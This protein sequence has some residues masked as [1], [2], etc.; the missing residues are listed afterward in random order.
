[1]SPDCVEQS[2]FFAMAHIRK[3]DERRMLAAA[4]LWIIN[5]ESMISRDDRRNN[6]VALLNSLTPAQ[7]PASMNAFA[8]ESSRMLVV[9]MTAWTIACMI[10][11]NARQCLT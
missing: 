2:S 5:E 9:L 7:M 11:C 6:G 10:T 8:R 3:L 1:M 4:K